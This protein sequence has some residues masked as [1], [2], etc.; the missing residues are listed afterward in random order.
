MNL[1]LSLNKQYIQER[2]AQVWGEDASKMFVSEKEE[3]PEEV[4]L[5]GKASGEGEE[6][7]PEEAPEEAVKSPVAAPRVMPTIKIP[8][9]SDISPEGGAIM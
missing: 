7:A 1:G 9:R 8:G 4:M 5:G 6:E 2:F 3:S